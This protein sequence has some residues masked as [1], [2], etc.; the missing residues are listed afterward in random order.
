MCL[1]PFLSVL[2]NSVIS[3]LSWQYFCI[4][5]VLLMANSQKFCAVFKLHFISPSI[6]QF[7]RIK[8]VDAYNKSYNHISCI[9]QTRIYLQMLVFHIKHIYTITLNDYLNSKVFLCWDR[10]SKESNYHSNPSYTVI[11]FPKDMNYCTLKMW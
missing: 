8:T 4:K 9:S 3:N 2:C 6:C 5:R 7:V 10:I 1:L 11:P